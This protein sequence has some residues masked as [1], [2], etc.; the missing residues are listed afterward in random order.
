MV[1]KVLIGG[2]GLIMIFKVGNKKGKRL[3]VLK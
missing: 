2:L 3:D 1:I